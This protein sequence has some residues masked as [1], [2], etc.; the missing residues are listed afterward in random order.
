[1]LQQDIFTIDRFCASA[2]I[3]RAHYYRLKKIG[4]A[5]RLIHL[6]ARVLISREAFAE[7]RASVEAKPVKPLNLSKH[8]QSQPEAA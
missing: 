3:S 6:G 4:R 2:G 8:T 7:W 1:M 5:P